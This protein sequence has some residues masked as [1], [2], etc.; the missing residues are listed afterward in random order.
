MDADRAFAAARAHY[1]KGTRLLRIHE[2]IPMEEQALN[3]ARAAAHFAAGS[4]A[5]DMGRAQ[6]EFNVFP[7]DDDD[8]DDDDDAR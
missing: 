6:M 2:V 8:D 5:I 3:F 1:R 7:D 4:L